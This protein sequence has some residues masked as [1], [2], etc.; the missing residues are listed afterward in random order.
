MIMKVAMAIAVTSTGFVGNSFYLLTRS[1]VNKTCSGPIL[2]QKSEAVNLCERNSY[3]FGTFRIECVDKPGTQYDTCTREH[4]PTTPDCSGASTTVTK[5]DASGQCTENN[6]IPMTYLIVA[7]ADAQSGF[8]RPVL[9]QW[10]DESCVGT[11]VEYI[12]YGICH[13]W[14]DNSY[15]YA[16]MNGTVQK[17]QYHKSNDCTGNGALCVP[18]P[19]VITGQCTARGKLGGKASVQY[20]C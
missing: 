6:G 14:D 17:C 4:Y 8:S 3:S 5:F 7:D 2:S 10:Q 20:D 11:P 9:R 15:R 18:D 12:D 16:C 19:G 1:Y 13:G